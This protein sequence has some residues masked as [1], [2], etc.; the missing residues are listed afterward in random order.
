MSQC[1]EEGH[2]HQID[3][4]QTQSVGKLSA[5]TGKIPWINKIEQSTL[6]C[7]FFAVLNLSNVLNFNFSTHWQTFSSFSSCGENIVTIQ[8]N[9]VEVTLERKWKQTGGKTSFYSSN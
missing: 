6:L 2:I 7:S 1:S 3:K 4:R 8:D 9:T 5:S